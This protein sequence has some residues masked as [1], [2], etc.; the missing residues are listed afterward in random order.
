MSDSDEADGA[1][2]DSIRKRSFPFDE[3]GRP[4]CF[5]RESEGALAC[6]RSDRTQENPPAPRTGVETRHSLG[7][8]R[9]FFGAVFPA[10][11]GVLPTH[12]GATSCTTRAATVRCCSFR[13]QLRSKIHPAHPPRLQYKES[14]AEQGT[15]H[16]RHP[17][18]GA[19]CR[20]RIMFCMN[21]LNG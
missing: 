3:I 4:F 12:C 19:S 15:Q 2:P 9:V 6:A 17:P 16:S 7:P 21:V 13:T 10:L 18:L 11:A 20:R 14:Q 8:R 5:I 1:R